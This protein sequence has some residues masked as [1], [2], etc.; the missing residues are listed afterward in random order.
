MRQNYISY[1]LLLQ[2]EDQS[3]DI[4]IKNVENK[5]SVLYLSLRT[6]GAQK[7]LRIDIEA[8][9][10]AA[11]R[12]V[13][14]SRLRHLANF[15]LWLFGD[16]THD[17]IITDS[18]DVDRFGAVLESPKA[19]EYLERTDNPTFEAAFRIAGGDEAETA[20]RLERAADEIEEALRTVHHHKKSKRVAGAVNRLTR[21]MTQLL[22]LFPTA[23]EALNKGLRS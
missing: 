19:V 13:P 15:A 18:R 3:E 22:V 16:K 11:R 20:R 4:S 10:R 23:K 14:R 8:D 9:P 1:N 17:E 7:Y 5:F 2:M 12:P 21:D 6:V